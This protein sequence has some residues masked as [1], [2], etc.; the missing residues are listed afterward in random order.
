MTM[1]T[2]ENQLQKCNSKVIY[3]KVEELAC[4]ILINSLKSSRPFGP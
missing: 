3:K 2:K 1:T 4:Y